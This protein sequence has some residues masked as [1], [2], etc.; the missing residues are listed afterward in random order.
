MALQ[1]E[2]SLSVSRWYLSPP[3]SPLLYLSSLYNLAADKLSLSYI[4]VLYYCQLKEWG[5][6]LYM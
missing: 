4:S 6:S 3:F 2:F 5:P 1:I